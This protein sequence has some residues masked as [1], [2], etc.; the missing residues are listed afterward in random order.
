MVFLINGM[1]TLYYDVSTTSKIFIYELYHISYIIIIYQ[2][3][4]FFKLLNINIRLI[5]L[6]LL[7]QTYSY[8]LFFS[9][10]VCRY[11]CA[12]NSA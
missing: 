6:F 12:F 1:L 3:S 8:R 5:Q 9:F 11:K 4:A 10:R 7:L 2:E